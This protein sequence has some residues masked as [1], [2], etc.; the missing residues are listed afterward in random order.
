MG[1]IKTVPVLTRV[2]RSSY[3]RPNRTD[4]HYY[5]GVGWLD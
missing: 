5:S 4:G 2:I 1:R 3:V